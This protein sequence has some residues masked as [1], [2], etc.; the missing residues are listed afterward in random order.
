MSREAF[1]EV[2]FGR[3]SGE[4]TFCDLAWT[5]LETRFVVS[6]FLPSGADAQ[7]TIVRCTSSVTLPGFAV[8]LVV[9]AQVVREG[10]PPEILPIF[11]RAARGHS[12]RGFGGLASGTEG[13]RNGFNSARFN[14]TWHLGYVAGLLPVRRR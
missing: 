8:F 13:A 11:S 3:A 2:H 1:L 7:D 6:V 4:S 12:V 14:V 10:H 5:D 9:R